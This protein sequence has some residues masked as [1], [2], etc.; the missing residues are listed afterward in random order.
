MVLLST[1]STLGVTLCRNPLRQQTVVIR[2]G[3]KARKWLI[4][5]LAT[6][7]RALIILCLYPQW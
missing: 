7:P 6:L 2:D 3:E 1:L 4:L 5:S